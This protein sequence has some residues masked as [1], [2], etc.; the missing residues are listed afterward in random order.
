MPRVLRIINRYNIGGPTYNAAYLSRFLAPEYET[1]LIGGRPQP[2]E[3]HS[4]YILDQLG[5]EYRE[6]GSFGRSLSLIDDYKTFREIRNIIR[7]FNPD[8][9]HTHAAKAGALGRMAAKMEK[10]P[11]IVHTFHGHVF[12]GYFNQWKSSLVQMIERFLARRSDAIVAISENQKADLCQ[13]FRI[14]PENKVHIIPLGLDLRKFE[15]DMEIKRNLFRKEYQLEEEIL[16]IGIIGRLT[17]IKNHELFLNSISELKK[18]SRKKIIAFIIGDGEL[19]NELELL[20]TQ[21]NLNTNDSRDVVFTSWIKDIDRAAAGMDIICLTSINEGTP[22]SLI[23]AQAAS[24]P[25]VS[26]FVGGVRDV[27]LN[28]AS[29]FIVEEQS[30][31]AIASA[32]YKLTENSELRKSMGQNGHEWAN[33]KFNYTRLVND[34]SSLYASLLKNCHA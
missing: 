18:L 9:V 24:R 22:V 30:A 29:G 11:V 6:I 13:K 26:T 10:V 8:I 3:A 16:A 2:Q 20:C 1:L 14:A 4:G 19:K 17:A 12:E 5:V 34:M 31:G 28:N 33:Q 25:V 23:E 21:L 15:T 32:L 27:M 7:D